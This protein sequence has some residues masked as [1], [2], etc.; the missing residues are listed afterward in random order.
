MHIERVRSAYRA[1]TIIALLYLFWI[2]APT[3]WPHVVTYGHLVANGAR[4]SRNANEDPNKLRGPILEAMLVQSGHFPADSE[5]QCQP[6]NR[7]WDYVCSYMPAPLRSRA[8]L[9]FGVNVDSQRWTKV[10]SIV[11]EGTPVPAPQ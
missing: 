11:A 1:G 8:R 9:Q 4:A 10:S 6:A 7:E 3:V 2:I 5:P